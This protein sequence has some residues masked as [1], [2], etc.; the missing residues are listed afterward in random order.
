ML[1]PPLAGTVQYSRDT[2]RQSFPKLHVVSVPGSGPGAGKVELVLQGSL[3]RY[4]L[5]CTDKS[6]LYSTGG[7][8]LQPLASLTTTGSC[9]SCGPGGFPGVFPGGFHQTTSPVAG[10]RR[11]L[12]FPQWQTVATSCCKQVTQGS[13]ETARGSLGLMGSLTHRGMLWGSR[14][15]S[16][17]TDSQSFGPNM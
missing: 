5:Y 1:S 13:Q 15:S 11:W 7:D 3:Y 9:S 8:Y 14:E 17:P 10:G 16:N 2:L 12:G 4:Q 6:S